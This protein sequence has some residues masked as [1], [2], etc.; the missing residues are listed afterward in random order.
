MDDILDKYFPT[1]ND[2]IGFYFIK[3]SKHQQVILEYLY[4]MSMKLGQFCRNL[5]AIRLACYPNNECNI[6]NV[7]VFGDNKYFEDYRYKKCT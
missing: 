4:Y 2:E 6:R 3:D 7:V 5:F 1:L